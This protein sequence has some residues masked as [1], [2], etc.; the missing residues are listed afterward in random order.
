MI[1]LLPPATKQSYR[2]AQHNVSLL[3]W[4]IAAMIGLV[5]VG[6][7]GCYGWL[8]LRQSTLTS[9][10]QIASTQ[11]ELQQANLEQTNKKVTDI[12]NSIKLA[13]KVL[14]Q[15]IL[16][17]KLLKQMA[18]ALPDGAN[19]TG[20]NIAQ[21]SGGSALD[22]TA[23]ATNYTVATQVQVNLADPTNQI[24]AKAD[25][26]N[27]TCDAAG[28]TNPNYPCKIT[29]RAQFGQNNPFLFINQKQVKS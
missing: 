8:T 21:V 20:L 19:L 27:I 28:A 2:Y 15:E 17:S 10:Q 7:I 6:L 9:E 14:S 3:N 16:F 25:I 11:Q 12:S 22:V 4:I 1:N 18:T 5:G 26:Q 23:D 24:F 29:L 13:E